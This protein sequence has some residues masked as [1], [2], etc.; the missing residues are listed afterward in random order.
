MHNAFDLSASLPA[1]AVLLALA[2]NHPSE[3]VT[4][5]ALSQ[6][7][8]AT[9]PSPGHFNSSQQQPSDSAA[10][11]GVQFTS[12]SLC[13]GSMQALATVEPASAQYGRQRSELKAEEP[14]MVLRL[15][16]EGNHALPGEEQSG[17]Q[18]GDTS[19]RGD[20]ATAAVAPTVT[21]AATTAA[22]TAATAAP[23]GACVDFWST[24]TRL[25]ADLTDAAVSQVTYGAVGPG[26]GAGAKAVH[27]HAQ[28]SKSER[29]SIPEWLGGHKAV[30]AANPAWPLSEGQVRHHRAHPES[31][32]AAALPPLDE[33][34]PMPATDAEAFPR[35]SRIRTGATDI[36]QAAMHQVRAY[37]HPAPA[38][39]SLAPAFIWPSSEGRV[40]HSRKHSLQPG[41]A[42]SSASDLCGRPAAV[43]HAPSAASPAALATTGHAAPGAGA[44]AGHAASGAGATA[45]IAA[46]G[47]GAT[48][49]SAGEPL[50]G[51]RGVPRQ[52]SAHTH[53][54][55]SLSMNR[56]AAYVHGSPLTL[57]HHLQPDTMQHGHAASH[58]FL[59]QGSLTHIFSQPGHSSV[60]RS[61][62]S[63]ATQ[64]S[65]LLRPVNLMR[66]ESARKS[67]QELPNPGADSSFS[68]RPALSPSRLASSNDRGS[69]AD[70]SSAHASV[71]H[72]GERRITGSPPMQITRSR[73]SLPV[74]TTCSPPIR[75]SLAPLFKAA[76]VIGS[77]MVFH[78][79]DI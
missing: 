67:P 6:L 16:L 26:S 15:S 47:A 77:P 7:I 54:D 71:L 43:S 25:T 13:S 29:G 38:P 21:A 63:C 72:G 65:C 45:C 42:Q 39:M 50:H 20:D 41:P 22:M 58:T 8:S 32:P 3:A 60:V 68:G 74:A 64:P 57:G 52:A 9:L 70:N 11:Q 73:T 46:S 79:D 76:L 5:T 4:Q 36:L 59:P 62:G 17:E 31:N 66:P 53:Q 24:R 33:A 34:C 19:A 2:S 48:A 27:G 49:S 18:H 55:V 61:D 78:G 23:P 12:H 1:A 75:A 44:T 10:Q 56:L 14:L 30:A 37:G 28:P 69:N 35:A 51:A 40:V